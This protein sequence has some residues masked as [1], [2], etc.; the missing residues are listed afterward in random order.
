MAEKPNTKRQAAE[1]A[2][3][4]MA[5]LGYLIA[6]MAVWGFSGWLV[7]RWLHTG[8]IAIAIG[9]VIGMAGGIYLVVRRF[10]I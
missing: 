10:G 6:G 9:V 5:A 8:G 2:N 1:G 3:T 4:G 7:D